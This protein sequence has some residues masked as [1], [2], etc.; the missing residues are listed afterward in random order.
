MIWRP[1]ANNLR[2]AYSEQL[3]DLGGVEGKNRRDTGVELP[4]VD[5]EEMNKSEEMTETKK[6]TK[7]EEKENENENEESQEEYSNL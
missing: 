4:V 7:R 2:Y 6:E 3:N 5:G 1:T